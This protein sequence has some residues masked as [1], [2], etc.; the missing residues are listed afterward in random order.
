MKY[1]LL[2]FFFFLFFSLNAQEYKPLDKVKIEILRAN[3]SNK[4]DFGKDETSKDIRYNIYFWCKVYGFSENHLVD[5]NEFSLVDKNRKIRFRPNQ[6]FFNEVA[7]EADRIKIDEFEIEDNFLRY[8][9]DG[10]E[11]YDHYFRFY[12]RGD[13]PKFQHRFSPEK[14]KK[15][16][17]NFW[18]WGF[19]YPALKD[20]KE[21]GEF[22]LYWRNLIVGEIKFENGR[23]VSDK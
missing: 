10:F 18:K 21:S 9:L 20:K 13:Y 2:F 19:T 11:N 12:G 17:K 22:L 8:S 6:V 15:R 3:R 5:M 7:W 16:R 4:W 14:F 1:S 23:W